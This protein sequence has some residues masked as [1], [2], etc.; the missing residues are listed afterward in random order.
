MSLHTFAFKLL[1]L[2]PRERP[3]IVPPLQIKRRSQKENLKLEFV[4]IS[5]LN[6]VKFDKIRRVMDN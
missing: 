4:A 3:A 1:K 6:F 5:T 2:D